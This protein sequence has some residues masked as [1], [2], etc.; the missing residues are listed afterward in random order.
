MPSAKSDIGCRRYRPASQVLRV[1]PVDGGIDRGRNH[2]TADSAECR[3]GNLR[4]AGEFALEKLTLDF[5]PHQK[6]EHRHQSIIDPKQKR[7]CNDQCTRLYGNRRVQKT[8]VK[9]AKRRVG[10]NDGRGRGYNQQDAA[11]GFKPQKLPDHRDGLR[12]VRLLF[13]VHTHLL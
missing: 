8:V 1:V 10:K 6:K 12:R 7:L 3:Q 9:A 5:Q 13:T 4:G 11:G 2:H